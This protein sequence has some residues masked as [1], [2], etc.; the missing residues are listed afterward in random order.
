[1]AYA[2][3]ATG[4]SRD[5]STFRLRTAAMAPQ[6]RVEDARSNQTGHDAA[7]PRAFNGTSNQKKGLHR[8]SSRDPKG[9]ESGSR[10]SNVD[11]DASNQRPVA[12]LVHDPSERQ[13]QLE[14]ADHWQPTE[15][16]ASEGNLVPMALP[17]KAIER[18]EQRPTA[19]SSDAR[20]A[21]RAF[22]GTLNGSSSAGQSSRPGPIDENNQGTDE[23]LSMDISSSGN[24]IESRRLA[25]NSNASNELV[26]RERVD[27]ATIPGNTP[28]I[29]V[30][31]N[32]SE[33]TPEGSR[34]T[35]SVHFVEKPGANGDL[36]DPVVLIVSIPPNQET[37]KYKAKDRVAIWN[38]DECRKIS[39]NAAPLARNLRKYLAKYTACEV[40]CGQDL[41]EQGRL[42]S[43]ETR[44]GTGGLGEHVPIWNRVKKLKISG[45]AS[46]LAKNLRAYLLRHP[47]C[48]VYTGQDLTMGG[49]SAMAS[50]TPNRAA[51]A[52]IAT[53]Q[54]LGTTLY[55]RPGTVNGTGTS[56]ENG[57]QEHAN[58]SK[59]SGRDAQPSLLDDEASRLLL[60]DLAAV[61]EIAS[62]LAA[63]L[64]GDSH[65]LGNG[66]EYRCIAAHGIS[67]TC[68]RCMDTEVELYQHLASSCSCSDCASTAEIDDVDVGSESAPE[69]SSTKSETASIGD[70]EGVLFGNIEEYRP[71]SAETIGQPAPL[72]AYAGDQRITITSVRTAQ[73]LVLLVPHQALH[74]GLCPTPGSEP[75]QGSAT[76]LRVDM[77]SQALSS[78]PDMQQ[79]LLS[80][81]SSFSESRYLVVPGK[82]IAAALASCLS[83][84]DESRVC[85]RC[86]LEQ[87]D[88]TTSD[89]VASV[90]SDPAD[91][92]ET[93]IRAV[94]LS[95]PT[96]EAS[97]V[98]KREDSPLPQPADPV[99]DLHA[100]SA[101]PWPTAD[102]PSESSPADAPAQKSDAWQV[103]SIALVTPQQQKTNFI[104]SDP[105]SAT[106][107]PDRT[108]EATLELEPA[109]EPIT[110]KHA[111][112]VAADLGELVD[113]SRPAERI[114]TRHPE[115]QDL[116]MS[117]KQARHL[118]TDHQAFRR[119]TSS[120]RYHRRTT[121]SEP[122]AARPL[123]SATPDASYAS[124]RRRHRGRGKRSKH[125]HGLAFAYRHLQR[126]RQIDAYERALLRLSSDE[127]GTVW[128]PA[129][130]DPDDNDD[131][132]IVIDPNWWQWTGNPFEH[133]LGPLGNGLL[134]DIP[135]TLFDDEAYDWY[136]SGSDRKSLHRSAHRVASLDRQDSCRVTRR[137]PA[138]AEAVQDSSSSSLQ[139]TESNQ[140]NGQ[141]TREAVQDSSSSSSFD[142]EPHR[143]TDGDIRSI[144]RRRRRPGLHTSLVPYHASTAN[145]HTEQDRIPC[146]VGLLAKTGHEHC[147]AA[148]VP[149]KRVLRHH[150]PR[151][152]QP[153]WSADA[154][155]AQGRRSKRGRVTNDDPIWKDRSK[156]Q[157]QVALNTNSTSVSF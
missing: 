69:R 147:A 39:G 48:E 155:Q 151:C 123:V 156:R 107:D 97:R 2:S 132:D 45:N 83:V 20:V 42:R 60:P 67:C 91:V 114:N 5:A 108:D 41:D 137:R 17:S 86:R 138:R 57:R 99:P 14:E 130:V 95:A 51:L 90:V 88:Q 29:K 89:R 104:E 73:G 34:M 110:M 8:Q 115:G 117:P 113:P 74:A 71:V 47:D 136:E 40:Y 126:M 7:T 6:A 32:P 105:K 62:A 11:L 103:S 142:T 10:D 141:D 153:R 98:E 152:P 56:L 78:G 94:G 28:S 121:H 75:A 145:E 96:T 122:P 4:T 109:A 35:G 79:T 37:I 149:T 30:E 33:N 15:Q 80:S 119:G 129:S 140:N 19:A 128:S 59:V 54:H 68:R 16:L 12:V 139:A 63:G 127:S 72:P 61:P 31:S 49:G 65:A 100:A 154:E 26:E 146:R 52:G 24:E 64:A 50:A 133:D 118:S 36:A 53:M 43:L 102:E 3:E 135:W 131:G 25:A 1:M 144:R 44:G 70:A 116:A 18:A 55:A 66:V 143:K 101:M 13:H 93:I 81:S 157:S 22:N 106:N 120:R 112:G 84:A 27:N 58:A 87:L 111:V 124:S 92:V 82:H 46:P 148:S 21:S 23:A 134:G 125:L 38:R 76:D 9:T 150:D 77:T 85:S